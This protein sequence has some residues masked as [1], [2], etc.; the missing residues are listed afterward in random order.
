[1]I[2]SKYVKKATLNKVEME[3]TSKA[4]IRGNPIVKT[5]IFGANGAVGRPS[6]VILTTKNNYVN[7]A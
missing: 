7:I 2:D 6:K 4:D 5:I 1:M 3:V